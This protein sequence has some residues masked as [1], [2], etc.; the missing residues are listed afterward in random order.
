[1]RVTVLILSLLLGAIMFIQT[2]LVAGLGSAANDE[3]TAQ[4]GSVGLFMSLLW[5][6]AAAL[7]L[8]LPMVSV[9]LFALAGVL[10]FAA[11][12]DFPDLA[13]WGGIS[14][15]LALLSFFGWRGKRKERR[16]RTAEQL[17][18]RE[19]D[20]RMEAMLRQQG[21]AQSLSGPTPVLGRPCP[22][23][24]APNPVGTRF[25]GNC[26]AAQPAPA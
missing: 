8:P 16:E 24:G 25:C 6:V 11:S 15:A 2:T 26:G 23:C 13:I 22:A 9:I 4:S 12:G 10:G 7:V 14:L 5:L 18:Q 3:G 21:Q 17:R 19:R 1:M 20:D